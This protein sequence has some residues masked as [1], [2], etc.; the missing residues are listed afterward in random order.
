M[1]DQDRPALSLVAPPGKRAAVL[2][3]AVEAERRGFAGIACP[4]L[5]NAMGLCASLAH[6]TSEIP[7]WT[8]IQPIY[9]ATAVETAGLAS[10]I[11]EVSG[12]RFRLGLGVSHA[13]AHRRLGVTA[14]APLEDTR[15]YV[16]AIRAAG[17]VHPDGGPL[18]IYLA[19]LR[20]GMLALASEIAEGAI[21]ANA[22]LSATAAQL[23]R[24]PGAGR[25]G[26]FRANMI[27]T[28]I[29]NDPDAAAAVNRRTMSGYLMLPNY[30]R[31]WRAA[32][33]QEEMDA[34]ETAVAAGDRDRLP[35]LVSDG[36][37]ADVTLSGPAG[38]VRD[39]LAAWADRGVLPIAVMSS[40]SGGQVKAVQELFDAFA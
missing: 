23:A 4:S 2:A 28:V 24:V 35:S 39:G 10:H 34:V 19:T 20:D 32:G 12:G 27:P 1:P 29:D 11:A 36:W 26:F 21:W 5:G 33:Y 37:L 9:L 17:A 22:A 18:P 25:E 7:F 13:P 31:Y 14:G 6:V 38:V 30:R 15:D 40:T 3:L 8:S 16:A